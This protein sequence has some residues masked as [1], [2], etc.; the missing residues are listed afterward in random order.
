MKP[1]KQME[2]D[3]IVHGSTP[4]RINAFSDGVFAI[5]IT[6]MILELKRPSN[7][8]FEALFAEWPTWISYIASYIFIAIVWINHHYLLKHA[9][10]STLRLMWANFAHLFSVSLIPF[11]TDWMAETRLQSVPVVM[12]GFVFLL[13]NITYLLLIRETIGTKQSTDMPNRVKRL[14]H[15]R[16]IAT[17]LIFGSGMVVALWRLYVGFGLICACLILYLRPDVPGT[18]EIY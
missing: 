7:P 4:E 6:I 3:E 13:V 11:T 16:S 9:T 5:V 17:I 8:T 1:N 12:Y 18:S 2:T 15:I 14:F 10:G